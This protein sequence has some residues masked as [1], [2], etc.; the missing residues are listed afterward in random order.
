MSLPPTLALEIRSYL[1][2]P[3]VNLQ[4]VSHKQI[5]RH[6]ATVFTWLDVK[7]L[8]QEINDLSVPIFT[9]V[10]QAASAHASA[11][12]QIAEAEAE[13]GSQSPMSAAALPFHPTGL[14]LPA[15]GI[16][17]GGEPSNSSQV[18]SNRENDVLPFSPARPNQRTAA[19][20]K[21]G[22]TK[23]R[24]RKSAAFVDSEDDEDQADGT[25]P[26]KSSAKKPRAP[27]TSADGTSTNKGFQKELNCS[28]A[29]AE[30]I[31]VPT[32]SR[33]QVVKKLWDYIKSNQLQNP[34]DK[35][36]IICDDRMRKLFNTNSVHMF[37]M[38]KLLGQHLWT[39]EEVVK[40]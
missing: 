30:V 14:V 39:N 34:E 1:S 38:N 22:S 23:S 3:D 25:K 33:P 29:L 11:E 17:G 4:T 31:G 2:R 16:P 36:Q 15:R 6:V 35:R 19:N 10:A 37:T 13:Q 24:K 5:R 7:A 9:E 20:S 12:A 28:P 27:R 8:K 26:K 18:S 21:A 40:P 32:C